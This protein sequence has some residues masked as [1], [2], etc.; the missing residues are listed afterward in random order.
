M[1]LWKTVLPIITTKRCI[2]GTEL[3]EDGVNGYLVD[4]DDV[5]GLA[6]AIQSVRDNDRDGAFGKRSFGNHS[7]LFD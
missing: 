2:A 5:S 7:R 4:A 1:K 3:I 6:R